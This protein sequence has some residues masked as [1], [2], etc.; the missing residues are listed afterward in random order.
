LTSGKLTDFRINAR[1]GQQFS[2]HKLLLAARS[3]VFEGMLASGMAE[4]AGNEMTLTDLSPT[5]IADMLAYIYT[6]T[7][8]NLAEKARDLLPVAEKYQLVGLKN[9]CCTAL[10][11]EIKLETAVELALLADLYG[12]KDLREAA[13]RFIVANKVHYQGDSAWQETFQSNP[14]LLYETWK[15]F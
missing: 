14:S 1:D 4:S 5:M 11:K 3:P 12:V 13:L 6:D 9:K 10:L 15:L 7:V 2:C 8:Q